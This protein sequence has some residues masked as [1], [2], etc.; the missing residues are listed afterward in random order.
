MM[1]NTDNFDFGSLGRDWWENIGKELGATPKQVRFA[2]AKH[3]GCSNT[4]SARRSGYTD[5][6]SNPGFLRTTAYRVARSNVVSRLLAFASGEA[7][8]PD[9][10]VDRK[11]GRRILSALARGSDPSVRIRA[12][13]QLAKFDEADRQNESAK[14]TTMEETA[15]ELLRTCPIYGPIIVADCVAGENE[16]RIFGMPFIK[17]LAPILKREFP[18]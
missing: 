2:C 14:E 8:G 6:P 4:E 12:I 3:R 11:E 13:E 1:E 15:L 10:N 17:E 9:G 7:D 18:R 16:G 5:D